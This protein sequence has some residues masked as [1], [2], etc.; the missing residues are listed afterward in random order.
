MTTVKI[1]ASSNVLKVLKQPLAFV[2]KVLGGLL[3]FHY[4]WSLTV[5]HYCLYLMWVSGSLARTTG[6]SVKNVWLPQY[7]RNERIKLAALT[8]A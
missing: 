2:N 4:C 8:V 3:T 1:S 6:G 5:L 7:R